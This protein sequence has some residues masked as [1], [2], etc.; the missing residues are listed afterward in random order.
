MINRIYKA[1]QFI[2]NNQVQGN[3]TPTEYNIALYNSI[4]EIYDGYYNELNRLINRENRGLV[5]EGLGDVS[6]RLREK[7]M[8]YFTDKN[9]R[10]VGGRLALPDDCRYVDAIINPKNRRRIESA[11]SAKE[12]YAAETLKHTRA[13]EM[14]AN[15]LKTGNAYKIAPA[16]IGLVKL[17]YLRNPL[18]P[19]WT[20]RLRN[21][22]N[23][24]NP[25]DP[26]F[27]NVDMHV[28]EE[29]PLIQSVLSQFG[30]NLKDPEIMQAA[31]AYAQNELQQ[32]NLM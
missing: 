32:D 10:V 16:S 24:Y 9:I 23:L 5:S 31:Q 4:L 14:F 2:T 22:A 19:N 7:I 18:K 12:F 30:I 15:S 6:E 26:M 13:T 25:S 21:N 29:I 1:V 3:V 27:Q 17:F 11:G 8:H 20:Y 28:S